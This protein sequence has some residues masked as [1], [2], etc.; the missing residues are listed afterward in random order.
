MDKYICIHGHFYQPPQ[1]NPWL[2]DF[3]LQDQAYPFHDWNEQSQKD[4]DSF[5]FLEYYT[6]KSLIRYWV[7]GKIS[8]GTPR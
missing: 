1:E 8:R 6:L 5:M 4:L 7:W 2:V 3:E